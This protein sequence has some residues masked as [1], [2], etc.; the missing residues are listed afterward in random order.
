M[1]YKNYF[2]LAYKGFT[3][4]RLALLLLAFLIISGCGVT[5]RM[6]PYKATDIIIGEDDGVVILARKHHASHEAETSL[7]N[8]ISN[9]IGSG[10]DALQV[11]PSNEFENTLYP[12]FEPSTA[13]LDTDSL[14]NL[15]SNQEIQD[16]VKRTGVRFL[17][18][19][20]G[21]T[22]RTASGGTISCAAGVG[23]A[24][25]MGL[26]WWEDDSN[27]EATIWDLEELNSAGSI[28]ADYL[29]RSFMPAI[30]IP[31]PLIARPQAEAC[32]GISDQIKL[33]LTT[34]YGN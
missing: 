12:W 4:L 15:L 7:I 28:Y 27:Y 18:W 6:E 31:I 32:R 1:P 11:Y 2:I 9:S 10:S 8:C 33:F 24:G 29:G 25:C 26:A 17:I 3:L 34:P 21:S 13:P 16:R 19:I 20:D 5:S 14:T 23:G 30:I 22:D